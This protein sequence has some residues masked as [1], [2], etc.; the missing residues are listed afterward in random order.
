MN[1][2]LVLTTLILGLLVVSASFAA[3]E[4]EIDVV[5]SSVGFSVRHLLI[6]NVTGNFNDFSGKLLFDEQ[7]ITKSSVEMTIQSGSINTNNADRDNHLR[8]GDFFNAEK[9]PTITFKSSKIEQVDGQYILHGSFTMHGVTKEIAVPF[10]FIGK[11][12]GPMGK[13]RLGFEG[14]TKIDRKDFGI[15]WNKTLDEGGLAVGN[16]VKVQLNIEAIKM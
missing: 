6:S 2:K 13:Q 10:E 15:S 4:Y 3:D 8:A 5:H 14:S 16:E 7:D 9:F 11:A 12:K 1:R